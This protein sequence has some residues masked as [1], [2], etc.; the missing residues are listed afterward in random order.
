MASPV[1]YVQALLNRETS[2][3]K[4]TLPGEVF[5]AILTSFGLQA[6]NAFYQIRICHIY[7]IFSQEWAFWSL[8][9]HTFTIFSH[10]LA[11]FLSTLCSASVPG[12]TPPGREDLPRRQHMPGRS[13]QSQAVVPARSQKDHSYWA[14][15]NNAAAARVP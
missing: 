3:G 7:I 1:V 9:C 10:L 6:A 11:T 14:Y 2:A 5:C 13:S 12:R 15:P 4:I 8:D